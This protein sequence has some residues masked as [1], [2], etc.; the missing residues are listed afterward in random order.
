MRAHVTVHFKCR[1]RVRDRVWVR[2]RVLVRVSVRFRCQE[3]PDTE[4]KVVQMFPQRAEWKTQGRV[5]VMIS[6]WILGHTYIWATLRV[7]LSKRLLQ[8]QSPLENDILMF[9]LPCR[10]FLHRF[11]NL[12]Q[13]VVRLWN[14]V[15][16]VRDS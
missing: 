7:G 14:W 3:P 9:H 8:L 15:P 11:L 5:P 6:L 12:E 13:A 4:P 1:V 16:M 10:V 2:L